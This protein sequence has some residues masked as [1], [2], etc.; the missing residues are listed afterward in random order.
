MNQFKRAKQIGH[1]TESI[2]DLKT[3][4]VAKTAEKTEKQN[5]ETYVEKSENNP[6]ELNAEPVNTPQLAKPEEKTD[7]IETEITL[8]I[9]NEAKTIAATELPDAEPIIVPDDISAN[10]NISMP[11]TTTY[12]EFPATQ[13]QA[14]QPQ[15]IAIPQ[16]AIPMQQQYPEYNVTY[17]EPVAAKSAKG[18]KKSAPNMFIQKS[19]SKSIRKSL[20]LRPSSVKI[21]ENYCTKNGGSFNELIQI[22]LDKFIEEYGL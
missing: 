2:T 7:T 5:T 8:P 6:A 13:P 16:A 20:V 3:A 19:E 15:T 14:M 4:G 10:K 21:A 22:L 1:Q 12:N 17:T 9:K 11:Q 18:T